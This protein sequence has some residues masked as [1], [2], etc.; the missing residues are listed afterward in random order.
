MQLSVKEWRARFI[1]VDRAVRVMDIYSGFR[2]SQLAADGS[3]GPLLVHRKF[4]ALWPNV[5][6]SCI[7]PD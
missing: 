1:V 6:K 3:E 4:V 7:T 5:P 2:A